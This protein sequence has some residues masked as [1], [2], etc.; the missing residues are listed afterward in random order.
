MNTPP[1]NTGFAYQAAKLSWVCPVIVLVLVP[2]GGRLGARVIIE[3][4]ALLLIVTGLIFGLIALA[5]I[6]KHGTKGIFAPAIVGLILNGFLLFIF[7]TNFMAARARAIQRRGEIEAT[8]LATVAFNKSL[9]TNR[10]CSGEASLECSMLSPG[11]VYDEFST[12]R[13][14][15][16]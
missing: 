9:M 8:P 15:R 4:V 10:R 3:S 12:R 6:S 14:D 5:S 13:V 7:V 1:E 2:V 11:T 16:K